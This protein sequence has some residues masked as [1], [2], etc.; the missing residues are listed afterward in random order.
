MPTSKTPLKI[1][2]I[3]T[4]FGTLLEAE[5]TTREAPAL[6][7]TWRAFAKFCSEPID[8][9]DERLFFEANLSTSQAD[10]FYVHFSRTCYGREPI[11]HLWSH[12][13]I[14]DFVFPLDSNLEAF[15]V[16]VEAEEFGEDTD[17]RDHFLDEVQSFSALWNALALLTPTSTQIYIGES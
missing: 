11:G 7:A 5:G 2:D 8:C 9:D 6:P 14:C 17:A 16:T 13:L 1:S 15:N 4:R 12:E 3:S 10:S